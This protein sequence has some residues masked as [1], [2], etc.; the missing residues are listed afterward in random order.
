MFTACR[1][2]LRPQNFAVLFEALEDHMRG[3][4][5]RVVDMFRHIDIDD[6][7]EISMEEFCEV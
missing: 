5:W 4:Y 1:R 7:K 2:R 6:D 3:N